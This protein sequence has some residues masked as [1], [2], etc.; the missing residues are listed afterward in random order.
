M[1]AYRLYFLDQGGSI[2]AA[3]V[4]DAPHHPSATAIAANLADACGDA[5]AG[6]ELWQANQRV[7]TKMPLKGPPPFMSGSVEEA[8]I[9]REERILESKSRIAQSRRLLERVAKLKAFHVTK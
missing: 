4:F 6:F 5:C 2:I 8:V 3:D 7:A 9:E 1:G